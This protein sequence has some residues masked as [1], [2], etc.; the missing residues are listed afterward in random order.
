MHQNVP[1]SNENAPVWTESSDTTE[2]CCKLVLPNPKRSKLLLVLW[3]DY[4]Q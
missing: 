1:D 3:I 2:F 4:R